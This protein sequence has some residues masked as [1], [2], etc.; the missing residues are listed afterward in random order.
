MWITETPLLLSPFHI[1]T[2]TN[3]FRIYILNNYIYA[4][5]Y[6]SILR[7]SINFLLIA[8]F[9]RFSAEKVGLIFKVIYVISQIKEKIN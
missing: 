8:T 7:V 3:R 4:P 1:K 2:Y 5:I 6:C 9:G